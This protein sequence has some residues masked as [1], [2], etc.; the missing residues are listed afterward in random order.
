MTTIIISV[1]CCDS[2]KACLTPVSTVYTFN[3]PVEALWISTSV[4]SFLGFV[5]KFLLLFGHTTWHV[6]L[7]VPQPGIKPSPPAVE[8]WN[9]NHWTTRE[10]PVLF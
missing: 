9:F 8:A 5:F 7:F 4:F 6:G 2:P 3:C 10:V 1:H